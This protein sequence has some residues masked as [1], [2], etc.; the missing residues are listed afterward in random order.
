MIAMRFREIPI[1][2]HFWRRGEQHRYLKDW[3]GSAIPFADPTSVLDMGAAEE[4]L[5]LL[6]PDWCPV[7]LRELPSPL[8]EVCPMCRDR[9]MDRGKPEQVLRWIRDFVGQHEVIR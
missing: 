2:A 7:C 6:D 8:P 1:G 9:Q 4:E 3:A 5:V